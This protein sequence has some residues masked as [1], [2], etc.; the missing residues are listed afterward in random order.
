MSRPAAITPT[1]ERVRKLA[2]EVAPGPV[3]MLNLLDFKEG[4]L[5]VFARYGQLTAPLIEQ[6]KGRVVYAGQAGPIIASQDA[7]SWDWVIL[8]EFPD[9]A[10]FIEMVSGDTY[11]NEAGPLRDEALERT[12]WM[13]TQ[14]MG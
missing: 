13:V 8:V 2:D 5:E 4:G 1:A 11:Q 12:L 14:Q 6:A 7:L 3:V 9:I 10:H